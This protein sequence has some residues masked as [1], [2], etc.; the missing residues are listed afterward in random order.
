MGQSCSLRATSSQMTW[1]SAVLEP[2]GTSVAAPSAARI[3]GLVVGAAEDRSPADVVDHEQVAAL[4]GQL[5]AGELEHRAGVVAGLG[6]EAHHH[7]AG[8]GPGG[9]SS[10]RMSGFWVSSRR[11]RGAVVGLLDLGLA[12]RRSGRKS[13]GAA[14]ITTA[15]AEAGGG[16]HRVAQLL[17]GLDPDHLDAGRVGQRD[18]GG[19]QGHLGAAGGRGAGQRVALQARGAV[20]EEAHRVEVLAGA[21]GGHHDLRPARSRLRR[22]RGPAR[23]WQ[24]SKISSGS[25]SR[26]LPVSAPVSRPSAGSMTRHAALAQRGDVGLG[27][28]VLPHLGV[29]RRGEDHRAAGGQQRVGEQVVGQAVGGLGQQVGGGRARP[30]PGRPT[31]RSGRAGT[32]WTSLP[33]LGRDRLAGQR[34]PGRRADEL[35]RRRGRYDGDVVAGLGEPAQQL[36]RPCRPRCRR[37]PRGRREAATLGGGRGSRMV[38]AGQLSARAGVERRRPWRRPP[39]R[40]ARPG[41]RPR[42]SAGRR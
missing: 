22:R 37:R 19:H 6:G 7:R 38:G 14:A 36:A 1:A 26:P 13:A 40:P 33:D 30:R 11:R 17:G 28:G 32:S 35:Q 42:R 12:D 4:A 25:G 21:A 41:R 9:A 24:T 34:R 8:P 31:G 5:G 39:R 16:Q 20:A 2:R 29:H 27:G 3:D 18:V 10:A 23:R 15:S